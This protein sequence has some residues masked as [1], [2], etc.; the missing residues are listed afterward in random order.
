ME[1]KITAKIQAQMEER[2]DEHI[3]D[4]N[5]QA[6]AFHSAMQ[7]KATDI[8]EAI[9][10]ATGG[11][12]GLTDSKHSA[13]ELKVEGIKTNMDAKLDKLMVQLQLMSQN[14][15]RYQTGNITNNSKKGTWRKLNRYCWT[16]G[17]CRHNSSDCNSPAD[18]HQNTATFETKQG[19]STDGAHKW[20][21]WLGPDGKVHNT[22]DG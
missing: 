9:S 11:T 19:G 1:A 22:K 15:N 4:F 6:T 7:S 21:K 17:V 16:H 18:N 8:P 20:G 12:S 2:L 5:E 10:T 14:D 3:D 13:L